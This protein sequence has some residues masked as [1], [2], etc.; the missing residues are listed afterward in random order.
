MSKLSAEIKKYLL[1]NKLSLDDIKKDLQSLDVDLVA[2]M[3][4]DKLNT[5]VIKKSGSVEKFSKEKIERS[6]KDAVASQKA[7]MTTSDIGIIVDDVID[8]LDN[9]PRK[10]YKTS[11]IKNYIKD[12]LLKEGYSKVYK[13]FISYIKED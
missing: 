3:L 10:V 6:I 13:E 1:E 11:E 8:S 2:D 7:A 5:Y 12:A 9:D 4:E